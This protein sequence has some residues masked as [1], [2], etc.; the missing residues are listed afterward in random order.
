[1]DLF[2][3]YYG[4]FI[5]TESGDVVSQS[6]FIKNNLDGFQKLLIVLNSLDDKENIRIGFKSTDHYVLNL[7]LF[8]EKAHLEFILS[9]IK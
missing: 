4:F 2:L 5:I 9:K 6:F 1:M 8:L 7:K 3:F